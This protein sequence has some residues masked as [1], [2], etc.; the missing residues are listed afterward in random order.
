M[1]DTPNFA[2]HFTPGLHRQ[3]PETRALLRQS[4]EPPPPATKTVRQII[5][6]VAAKHGVTVLELLSIRRKPKIC[7]ARREAYYRCSTETTLSFPTIGKHFGGRDHSTII[8]G[9]AQ[10]RKDMGL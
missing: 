5:E 7:T 2:P 6:E 10:Y 3:Y 8:H 9:A 1:S 4:G